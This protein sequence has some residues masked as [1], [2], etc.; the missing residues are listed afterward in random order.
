[1][2]RPLLAWDN[3]RKHG[4]DRSAGERRPRPACLI[5]RDACDQI[6]SIDTLH[7]FSMLVFMAVSNTS[8]SSLYLNHGTL[9]SRYMSLG[10]ERQF[11]NMKNAWCGSISSRF[12]MMSSSIVV[13]A[14]RCSGVES[15]CRVD[16]NNCHRFGAGIEMDGN[17]SRKSLVVWGNPNCREKGA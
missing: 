8:S 9:R 17:T 2:T 7:I 10:I 6:S 3:D 4:R 15:W 14:S 16:P 5:G 12:S 13:F 11:F 1:M